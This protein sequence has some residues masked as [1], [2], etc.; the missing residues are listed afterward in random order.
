MQCFHHQKNTI[1]KFPSTDLHVADHTIY[2][3]FLPTFDRLGLTPSAIFQRY[4][5]MVDKTSR[6]PHFVGINEY[7]SDSCIITV[8][9]FTAPCNHPVT[10]DQISIK[11]ITTDAG[12]QFTPCNFREACANATIE[13][14]IAASKHQEQHHRA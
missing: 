6:K 3:D 8:N 9:E 11:K 4:L 14:S 10:V 7:N 1:N 13:L 2:K 12:T 5:I